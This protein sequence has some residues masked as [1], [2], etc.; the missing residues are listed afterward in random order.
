[1]SACIQDFWM[2]RRFLRRLRPSLFDALLCII[3]NILSGPFDGRNHVP[4][5]LASRIQRFV[6]HAHSQQ[7][8]KMSIQA[9][10]ADETP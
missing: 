9:G 4:M 1:M 3:I 7:Q 10:S 8:K 5:E 6:E 2:M